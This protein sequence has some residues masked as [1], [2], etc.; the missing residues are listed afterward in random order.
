M[1]SQGK[2]NSRSPTPGANNNINTPPRIEDPY[3]IETLNRLY[4]ST[5]PKALPASTAIPNEYAGW[6]KHIEDQRKMLIDANDKLCAQD[7]KIKYLEEENRY[8]R[9]CLPPNS[10]VFQNES[11]PMRQQVEGTE[12]R[13]R[14]SEAADTQADDLNF[15]K[16]MERFGQDKTPEIYQDDTFVEVEGSPA[17]EAVVRF[18]RKVNAKPEHLIINS[19]AIEVVDLTNDDRPASPVSHGPTTP[20][21]NNVMVYVDNSTDNSPIPGENDIVESCENEYGQS[22]SMTLEENQTPAINREEPRTPQRSI[23]HEDENQALAINREKLQA[24]QSSTIYSDENHHPVRIAHQRF[25]Q[26]I[27]NASDRPHALDDQRQTLSHINAPPVYVFGEL[28]DERSTN[29]NLDEMEGVIQSPLIVHGPF[30]RNISILNFD[31][32]DCQSPVM[33][34]YKRRKPND[35]GSSL[36]Q[37]ILYQARLE[38]KSPAFKT[39][40]RKLLTAARKGKRAHPRDYPFPCDKIPFLDLTMRD[41][42]PLPA[43][44]SLC[45][46]AFEPMEVETGDVVMSNSDS[47]G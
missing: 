36:A 15:R 44:T 33:R 23:V 20:V 2:K 39:R 9:S 38:R 29:E 31:D 26:I 16:A 7:G 42:P 13:A 1:S 41:V 24:P 12:E 6:M 21:T 22:R 47:D 30:K 5:S 25:A 14:N 43:E 8:L 27:S 45:F 34:S 32:E 4:A 3:L 18:E 19:V 40:Q 11:T 10:P 28:L 46:E 35:R 17:A 37:R